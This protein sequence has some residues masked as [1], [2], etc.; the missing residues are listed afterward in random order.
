MIADWVQD[1]NVVD[2]VCTEKTTRLGWEVIGVQMSVETHHAPLGELGTCDS[3]NTWPRSDWAKNVMTVFACDQSNGTQKCC[4]Q[5]GRIMWS[6]ALN[7]FSTR[8]CWRVYTNRTLPIR[9]KIKLG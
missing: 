8:D 1:N 3:G 4:D 6:S 2:G 9:G 7:E 5:D